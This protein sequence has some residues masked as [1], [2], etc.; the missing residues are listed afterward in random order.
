MIPSIQTSFYSEILSDIDITGK[1][2]ETCS[3]PLKYAK[4]REIQV[5]EG[6]IL[7]QYYSNYLFFIEFYELE[8]ERELKTSYIV[9]EPAFFLFLMFEG[10]LSLATSEGKG[11]A[12]ANKGVFYANYKREGTTYVNSLP[13][14]RH[15]FCNI[16]PRAEW[17]ERKTGEFPALESFIRSFRNGKRQYGYMPR[18]FIDGKVYKAVLELCNLQRLKGIEAEAQILNQA[19]RIFKIY[20]DM[21]ASGSFIHSDTQRERIRM[22]KQYIDEYSKDLKIGDVQKIADQ[23]FFARR[24]LTRTFKDETGFTIQGYIEKAKLDNALRLLRET[25]LSIK[26]ISVLSGYPD[27][28]YFCR[29]FTREFGSSPKNI[30]QEIFMCLPLHEIEFS[31]IKPS[32][33]IH[34]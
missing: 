27:Q 4:A 26:E 20:N 25:K 9:K 22:V 6:K 18:C 16:T 29:V 11:I 19:I 1:L 24:T 13:P 32:G 21:I 2:P 10:T 5:E 23:F 12:N 34:N 14:G 7:M 8:L 3:F 31:T 15:K 17:L 33:F 28:N 30:R